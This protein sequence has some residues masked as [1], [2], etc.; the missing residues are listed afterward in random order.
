MARSNM[1]KPVQRRGASLGHHVNRLLVVTEPYAFIMQARRPEVFNRLA[2]K[3]LGPGLVI[4]ALENIKTAVGD[5]SGGAA[6]C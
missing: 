6:V 1:I 5:H 3:S 2:L 4:F